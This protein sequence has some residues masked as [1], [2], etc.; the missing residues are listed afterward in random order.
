MFDLRAVPHTDP[1]DIYRVRE[2]IYAPDMLLAAIVHLD[3]FSWLEKNPATAADVCRAFDTTRR[4]TDVMLTLFAAMGLVEE[5]HR[6]VSYRDT[7]A[8]RGVMTATR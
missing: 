7:A 6:G 1:A 4:P 3:L 2:G 5:R 8:A